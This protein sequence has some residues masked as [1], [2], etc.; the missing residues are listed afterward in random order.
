MVWAILSTERAA[1]AK[2]LEGM[3]HAQ[4]TIRINTA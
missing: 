3:R 2:A 4:M 1:Q